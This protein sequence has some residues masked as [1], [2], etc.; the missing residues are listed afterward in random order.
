MLTLLSNLYAHY[1]QILVT[2][3]AENNRKLQETY[4]PDEPLEIL[5]TK[6]NKCVDYATAAGEPITEGQVIQISYGLVV[7][8]G[9]FRK[10]DGLGAP[11]RIRKRPGHRSR[12]TSSRRRPTCGNSSRP[13]NK[14][15][16][17]PVQKK[18]SRRCPSRLP[19]WQ[20]PHQKIAPP[21]PT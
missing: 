5:Y 7:V 9:D 3:L 12:R 4:N 15:D 1:A 13:P 2:Y 19:I 16:T 20:R 10:T 14:G 21:S 6:L 17:T 8:T 18:T 11:I